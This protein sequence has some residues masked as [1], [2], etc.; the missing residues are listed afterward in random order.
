MDLLTSKEEEV[1]FD[2]LQKSQ[3]PRVR[4]VG[5]ERTLGKIFDKIGFGG[6]D[7]ELFRHIVLSRL[8][9]PVSKLK[10]LESGRFL[11]RF[12]QVVFMSTN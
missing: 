1:V 9:Y 4:M 8:T 3:A 12:H 6:I 7:E 2:Y 5:P 11:D 10:T